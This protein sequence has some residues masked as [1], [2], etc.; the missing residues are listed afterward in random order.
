MRYYLGLL[1]LVVA[2]GCGWA[3]MAG[4][5]AVTETI[6]IRRM[7]VGNDWVYVK[8][9]KLL[10]ARYI[11]GKGIG[12]LRMLRGNT[13]LLAAIPPAKRPG[14]LARWLKGPFDGKV[15]KW[16]KGIVVYGTYEKAKQ[17]NPEA[18]VSDES[19]KCIPV[20][21]LPPEWWVKRRAQKEE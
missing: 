6:A 11:P 3:P 8:G 1:L 18:K 4:K 20:E 15:V 19:K 12:P 2:S 7:V 17:A 9:T 14:F 21:K 10:Y 13:A 5:E 16:N